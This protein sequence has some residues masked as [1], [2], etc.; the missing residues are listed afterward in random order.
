MSTPPRNAFETGQP[1]SA[2]FANAANAPGSMPLRP[3]TETESLD[4]VILMPASLLSAVTVH[5]TV[6][7]SI[8]PPFLPIAALMTIA[9]QAACAP[10]INSSGLAPPR[11]SP[12]PRGHGG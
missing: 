6:V 9:K 12:P 11:G 2:S 5:V 4:V 1:F 7:L 10:A 8:D 3:S